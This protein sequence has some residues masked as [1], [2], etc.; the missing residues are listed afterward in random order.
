MEFFHNLSL[1]NHPP[2]IQPLKDFNFNGYLSGSE[3]SSDGSVGLEVSTKAVDATEVIIV[4][5]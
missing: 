1:H 4:I 5:I 3:G 2:S